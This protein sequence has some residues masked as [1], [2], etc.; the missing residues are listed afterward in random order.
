MPQVL[1]LLTLN[2]VLLV[3]VKLKP[4]LVL[5]LE[6]EH[7]GRLAGV[8]LRVAYSFEPVPE[9]PALSD[10]VDDDAVDAGAGALLLEAH[11]V[12][13]LP[14]GDA[15][16]V[17]LLVAAVDLGDEE[18]VELELVPGL[19]AVGLLEERDAVGVAGEEAGIPAREGLLLADGGLL[20]AEV[21]DDLLAPEALDQV[22]EELDLRLAVHLLQGHL[23]KLRQQPHELLL[24]A[25]L[26]DN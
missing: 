1:L 4:A 25:Q 6:L 14:V 2:A 3:V 10:E 9:T 19:L 12:L 16:D 20:A 11:L 22:D 23:L 5:P 13:V 8:Q 26:Q 18:L 17:A 7:G 24:P 15:E 21:L